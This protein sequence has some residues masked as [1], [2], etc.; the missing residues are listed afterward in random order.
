MGDKFTGAAGPVFVFLAVVLLTLGALCFFVVVQPT[1]AW[2]WLSTP[3]CVLLAVNTFTHYYY[4]CTIPPGFVN[5]SPHPPRSG[6]LWAKKREPSR[7]AGVRWTE[8]TIT[9]ASVTRCG[10]CGEMRPERSHHCRIC[11]RCVLKYDHHCPCTTT[12]TVY[13]VI[14]S[15]CL[16]ALG[17]R[18]VLSA[19][20]WYDEYWPYLIPPTIF[21]LLYILAT[22]MCFAVCI[23]A[24]WH[25]WSI[26]CG[27]TSVESQ[28][29]EQYRKMARGRGEAFVNSYDLGRRKNLELFFNVGQDGYPLYTLIL[30]L[31][32]EPYTDG[33]SWARKAGYERH[34]GIRQGEELTD[35]DDDED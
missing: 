15:F 27:E 21:L 25:I 33:Y 17:W 13:M 10:R 20:G 23:M 9:K 29:H 4:V 30:P 1:L 26:S 5:D 24:A 22:V 31:R 7:R 35:E 28:D 19:L 14:A 32:V 2:P 6:L 8:T 3:V 34:R 18:H 12:D 16:A 11:N